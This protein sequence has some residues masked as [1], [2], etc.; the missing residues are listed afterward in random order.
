MISALTNYLQNQPLPSSD[1]SVGAAP[2]TDSQAAENADSA[3]ND[4]LYAPS[5]RALMV[6][7]VASDYD[8]TSLTSEQTSGLQQRLQQYGLIGG[9]D[10]N[11]F[12]V[13]NTARADMN[14]ESTLN[15]VEL[16]DGA[17][18]QFT[19]RGASYSERQQ[20]TRLHTLMHNIASARPLQ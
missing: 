15:A 14:E 2:V 13:I 3:T 4:A 7:A 19:E 16:L 10:L 12:A 8:V 18:D 1:T 11:A 6:S 20:I 5:Q 17:M 9:T